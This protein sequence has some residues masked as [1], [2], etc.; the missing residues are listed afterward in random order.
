MHNPYSPRQEFRHPVTVPVQ[1]INGQPAPDAV[2]LNVTPHGTLLEG[3]VPFQVG[4]TVNFQVILPDDETATWV[5]GKVV[6][7]AAAP[8]ARRRF[9]AGLS[10]LSPQWRLPLTTVNLW[11][12]LSAREKLALSPTEH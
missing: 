1:E 2:L 6:W 5:S 3:P 10:F 8:Q 11:D 9:R 12:G 7:T 4:E